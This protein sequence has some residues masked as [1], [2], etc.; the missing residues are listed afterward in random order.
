MEES[1]KVNALINIGQGKLVQKIYEDLLSEPSKKAGLAL[2]TIV[3]VGNT[4]LW[5]VKWFNERTRIYFESNLKKY[6]KNLQ[7][8]PEDEIT[9]V[10]TEISNPILDR[11]VYVSNEELSDA[12]VKLLTSASSSKTAKNAHPGFIQIIDR[13]SPDEAKILK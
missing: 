4:V 3:N 6:E 8:V 12:F 5:P 2:S 13:I 9:E 1:S 11:F 10:P 7:E